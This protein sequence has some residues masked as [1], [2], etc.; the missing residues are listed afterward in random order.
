MPHD[1]HPLPTI[2]LIDTG[3]QGPLALLA[4]EGERARALLAQGRRRYGQL[5]LKLGDRVSWRWLERSRNPFRH[6][7]QAVA[8][9]LGTEGAALLNLSYEWNCSTG[10]APDSGAQGMRLLRVLDWPLD[11][12]GRHV[13]VARAQSPAGPWLNITWPGAV[14]VTTALAPGRFAAAINQPP[15]LRY[16]LGKAGDWAVNRVRV[17]QT[18]ALPPAHLLRQVFEEAADYE[19]AKRRLTQTPVALPALFIL[20]GVKSGEGAVIERLP[21]ESFVHEG[22]VACANHWL[23]PVWRGTPRGRYSVARRARLA[24]IQDRVGSGFAWIA[25]PILNKKT[26]VAVQANPSTGALEV[27]GFEHE[28]PATQLFQLAPDRAAALAS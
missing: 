27:Q 23:N 11:G 5:A 9:Q 25:P 4:A 19:E 15:M 17:W 12:L 21:R 26:R 7:I 14:G 8:E 13:V 18:T 20:A 2:P 28:A 24:E 10:V 1:P 16:G 6:E 22:V 3:G